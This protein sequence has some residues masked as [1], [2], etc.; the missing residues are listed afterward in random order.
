MLAATALF[1]EPLAVHSVPDIGGAGAIQLPHEASGR[2][3]LQRPT[4]AKL[5]RPVDVDAPALLGRR[6]DASPVQLQRIKAAWKPRK[7]PDLSSFTEDT[8]HAVW[9]E[10]DLPLFGKKNQALAGGLKAAREVVSFT[11]FDNGLGAAAATVAARHPNRIRAIAAQAAG[12]SDLVSMTLRIK[13]QDTLGGFADLRLDVVNT[14]P[15]SKKNHKLVGS[16]EPNTS[17]WFAYLAKYVV[18]LGDVPIPLQ[19]FDTRALLQAIW[20]REVQQVSLTRQGDLNN[21]NCGTNPF[22]DVLGTLPSENF[23]VQIQRLASTRVGIFEFNAGFQLA[24]MIEYNSDTARVEFD[25]GFME[26]ALNGDAI[27]LKSNDGTVNLVVAGFRDYA[28]IDVIRSKHGQ[29]TAL[30]L[31]NPQGY[32]FQPNA[33]ADGT[34]AGTA[35]R[36]ISKLPKVA[37][38]FTLPVHWLKRVATSLFF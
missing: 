23:D 37:A 11:D 33:A 20:G 31:Y 21:Q 18:K 8:A 3:L 38:D 15:V 7:D 9:F 12:D 25:D 26:S 13:T 14:L 30:R 32:N 6:I 10:T 34:A 1:V 27:R 24:S 4:P 29:P 28:V 35:S 2:Q 22:G 19:L 36:N 5:S 17:S 16:F